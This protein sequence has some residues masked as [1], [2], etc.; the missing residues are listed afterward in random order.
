MSIAI[1]YSRASKGIHAPLVTVETHL[2]PG[3]PKINIVGLPEEEVKESRERV[4]SAIINAG[5]TFPSCRITINLAPADLPKEGGRFDLPIALS[6]LAAS[7]QLPSEILHEYEFAGELALSG[8]L[9]AIKGVLPFALETSK[10]GRKLL[11]PESNIL[12]ATLIEKLK[13]FPGSDL[14][15]VCMHLSG[16][17]SISCSVVR[18][19]DSEELSEDRVDFKDVAGQKHAKRALEVAAAGGHSVLMAG[20][21][22]TGKTMMAMRLPTILPQLDEDDALEVAAIKSLSLNGFDAAEWRQR[23]FR[24]PHHTASAVALV[25]G[26]RTPRPGEISLAHHGV[27]FL[28]ELPEYDRKVLEVLREPIESGRVMISRA[29]HQTEF[30]AA[31]QFIAAMNPCPCGY[32]S[33]P[34]RSC[35]CTV[36]QINRYRNK[37][38]G[39]LMDRIDMHIEVPS[40]KST[41]LSQQTEIPESSGAI[42]ERVVLA[43]LRQLRRA[44]QI[45]AK[46][47]T[48][49]IK[50]FCHIEQT[51]R[52]F[53]QA[54]IE[55]L[56]LSARAY[57]RVLKVA[58]TI[59]DLEGK[60]NIEKNHLFEALSYRRLDRNISHSS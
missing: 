23:P 54:A 39:P 29:N 16:Q 5:L 50:Q 37:L 41:E 18:A 52:D 21:P 59:A 17:D 6:I 13:V 43:R 15:R 45:N 57:H 35:Q 53:L 30:P 9:R 25:G 19:I 3:L 1:A 12:E 46:L 49:Q 32:L 31:F 44:K 20:P 42:R 36:E 10:S 7:Q 8:E 38:S 48:R 2:S 4:R 40:L 28:D 47:G 26:G 22:G 34:K 58:R 24:A 11:I 60:D 51:E 56:G 55:K 14:L 33:D 27:L